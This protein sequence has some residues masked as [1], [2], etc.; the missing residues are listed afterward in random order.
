MNQR[1]SFKK[2]LD[3]GAPNIFFNSYAEEVSEDV[4]GQVNTQKLKTL[5]TLLKAHD[6]WYSMSSDNRAYKKGSSEQDAIRKL[7]DETGSESMKL[8]RA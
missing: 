7:A 4:P 8:Y 2:F 6:W 5:E 1:M 3:A